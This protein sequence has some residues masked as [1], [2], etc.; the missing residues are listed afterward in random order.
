MRYRFTA[1]HPGVF[2]YH[3]ATQPVLMHTGAGM[4]G[5]FVVKPK[6]LPAVDRELWATQQEFYIGKPGGQADMTKLKAKQ[7]D[8]IAFNGFADRHSPARTDVGGP[9][10]AG[11][12]SVDPRKR[13]CSG[14]GG[15]RTLGRGVTPTTV[16]E[17]ARFNHSRTPPRRN[18]GRR[19]G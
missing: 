16:F 13:A 14:G 5:M 12:R 3:C 1:D 11:R 19:A 15:I 8:V 10:C 9:P 6:G 7:P 17:T 18:N 4:A 2:M